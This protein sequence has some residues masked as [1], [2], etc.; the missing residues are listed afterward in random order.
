MHNDSQVRGIIGGDGD[1][2]DDH[3]NDCNGDHDVE[4]DEDEDV[5]M[6]K[7]ASDGECERLTVNDDSAVPQTSFSCMIHLQGKHSKKNSLS[8]Y[9]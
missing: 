9:G 1:G 5:N 4:Y 7:I 3:D 8:N 2:D 6:A